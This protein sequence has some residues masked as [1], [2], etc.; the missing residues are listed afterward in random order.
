MASYNLFLELTK[1]IGATRMLEL[2]QLYIMRHQHDAS[3]SR[4]WR[5]C[6]NSEPFENIKQIEPVFPPA[7]RNVAVQTIPGAPKNLKQNFQS[8]FIGSASPYDDQDT[9]TRRLSFSSLDELRLPALFHTVNSRGEC[10]PYS[11]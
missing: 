1:A 6:S 5:D 2:C 4:I 10:C 9:P 11:D 7:W 3:G 8:P